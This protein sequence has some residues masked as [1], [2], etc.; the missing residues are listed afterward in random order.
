MCT[1]NLECDSG[2]CG[3]LAKI[4]VCAREYVCCAY[5][6]IYAARTS[7]VELIVV[8]ELRSDDTDNRRGARYTSQTTCH[9]STRTAVE[10]FGLF[11]YLVP[12]IYES[13]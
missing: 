4:P 3:Q 9:C 6:Y 12:G 1:T 2:C 10:C 8:R 11:T 13:V 5:M 7:A